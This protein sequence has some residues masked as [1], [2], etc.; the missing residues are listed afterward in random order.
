MLLLVR[1]SSIATLEIVNLLKLV[2]VCVCVYI[3]VPACMSVHVQVIESARA[4]GQTRQAS[5][6]TRTLVAVSATFLLLTSPETLFWV[7]LPYIGLVLP[8]LI[9]RG[10]PVY[11]VCL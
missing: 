2:C 9:K 7:L 5:A 8:I 1:F 11:N 3:C 4:A 10:L 6:L